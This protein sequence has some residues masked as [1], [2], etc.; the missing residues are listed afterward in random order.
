[1][2]R[3]KC[4]KIVAELSRYSSLWCLHF[5]LAKSKYRNKSTKVHSIPCDS[6]SAY[7]SGSRAQ[8]LVGGPRVGSGKADDGGWAG[9][10]SLGDYKEACSR[11]G[12]PRT[13]RTSRRSPLEVIHQ[14][15]ESSVAP[16]IH[17]VQDTSWR[18]RGPS[19]TWAVRLVCIYIG[20][21]SKTTN[22][23]NQAWSHYK[24]ES[25]TELKNTKLTKYRIAVGF[26][27]KFH[28]NISRIPQ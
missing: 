1:M 17:A 4:N 3:I 8:A 19:V 2:C 21:S 25:A 28:S 7:L 11:C 15:S 16:H 12:S 27:S 14:R 26:F 20:L 10:W 23:Y 13:D 18:T 6:D 5:Q 9:S 24:G 22:A